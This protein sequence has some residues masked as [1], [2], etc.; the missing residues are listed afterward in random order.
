M[1]RSTI[2]PALAA[3]AFTLLSSVAAWVVDDIARDR[4]VGE[5]RSN[6]LSRLS[7]KR[8]RLESALNARIQTA[9]GIV[10]YELNAGPL[11]QG[12][13]S[14]FVRS[15]MQQQQGVI[16]VLLVRSAQPGQ[17]PALNDPQKLQ[18][19]T[20]P[21][22]TETQAVLDD[23]RQQQQRFK[24]LIPSGLISRLPQ[25]YTNRAR[26]LGYIPVCDGRCSSRSP[27]LGMVVVI[28]DELALLADAD[29][30][31][32]DNSTEYAIYEHGA[33]GVGRLLFGSAT[34]FDRDPVILEIPLLTGRWQLAAVPAQGWTVVSTS[35][36]WLRVG[37][38]VAIALGTVLTFLLVRQP[39]RLRVA[40]AQ[41]RETNRLL[42]EE[43]LDRQLA[44]AKLQSLA[45]QLEQRVLERTA[46]LSKALEQVQK[47][48]VQVV[49]SEKMSSLGQ[50]VAGVAHEINN[51][52]NFIYG[53]LGHAKDYIHGLLGFLELLHQE[54]PE[55]SPTLT[56]YAEA[57]DLEFLEDDLPQLLKSMEIG[58]ERICGIVQSL[59]IFS[60]LDESD[61]K[62]VDIHEGIDSTLTILNHRLKGSDTQPAILIH[63]E[64]DPAMP[65][66]ECYAGQLNQVFMNLLVNAIDALEESGTLDPQITI[67]TAL[68]DPNQLQI[69]IIDNGPGIATAAQ[70]K[71]FDA[72][73]TTKPVGKG[74]GMGL[75]ISYQVVADRH[76]GSLECVTEPGQGATFV[77]TIPIEQRPALAESSAV[78][79][80]PL[81][82]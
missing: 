28:F 50:L 40:I 12:Q 16:A 62:R 7:A 22:N 71:I 26:Y 32:N 5:A 1:N 10:P 14:A 76:K 44:E 68:L 61:L 2:V 34:V 43:I 69:R 75:S 48:Q 49:Q 25:P 8:A 11:S 67:A 27:L 30:L 77:I 55:L 31:N 17:P 37:E 51:P 70:S 45:E 64:Y 80:A 60:R 38:V 66:V 29:L 42:R 33:N 54:Q 41:T 82:T 13:F 53:N 57:I 52:I 63:R 39:M 19:L 9:Q 3:A 18:I 73:F 58:S 6:L 74:T 56:A 47:A 79:P 35:M 65:S 4:F 20:Y 72:F 36:L 24:R 46:E 59:R 15:L 21:P 23:Y 78:D 81:T